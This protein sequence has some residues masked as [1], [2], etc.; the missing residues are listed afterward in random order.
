MKKTIVSQTEVHAGEECWNR[1][2]P[3]PATR[4]PHRGIMHVILSLVG[5]NYTKEFCRDDQTEVSFFLISFL[6]SS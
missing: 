3:Q 6:S 4:I 1:R 5:K 2:T